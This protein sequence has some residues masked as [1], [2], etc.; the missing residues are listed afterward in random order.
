[1]TTTMD[2][3]EAVLHYAQRL[4]PDGLTTGT[5]G[6]ISARYG[7][8][9]AITPRGMDYQEMTLD[10]VCVVNLDGSQVSGTFAPSGETPIHLALYADPAV[11]AVV[12]MHSPYATVLSTTVDELPAIH[13][14]VAQLGGPVRVA[15]YAMPGSAALVESI[16]TGI[17][18]RSAVLMQNH[19]ALVTGPN[20]HEAY[21][22]AMTL[23][24]LSALYHRARQTTAEARVL[25][26]DEYAAVEA[27][28]ASYGRQTLAPGG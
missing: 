16:T 1:M 15:P 22:N 17:A 20:L 12:H 9:I 14:M 8:H 7:E 26:D 3:R 23:E 6:N 28:A 10:D 18:D 2:A 4:L 27:R 24:W 21:K 5:S 19:G 13:Y 25:T 11:G